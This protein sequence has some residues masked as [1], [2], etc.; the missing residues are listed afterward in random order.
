VID[1][2]AYLNSKLPWEAGG[3]QLWGQASGQY[4]SQLSGQ[5]TALQTPDKLGGGY[6]YRNYELPQINQGLLNGSIT[7][8]DVI[9]L[10]A[11]R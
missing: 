11:P 2:W 7:G 8:H 4:A 3:E 1:D 9:V 5:V 6:V 10:P